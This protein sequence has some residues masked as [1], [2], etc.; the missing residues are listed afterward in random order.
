MAKKAPAKTTGKTTAKAPAKTPAKR[1]AK[2]ESPKAVKSGAPKSAAKKASS[3]SYSIGEGSKAPQI[4][5]AATSN[6]NLSN[7]DFSGRTVVLYFYPKD[8]TPGCTL[9]GQDF[10]RLYK[11]FQE[12]KTEIVGVSQDTVASHEK[13]K[14]KCDFPFELLSDE[15][16][17]LCKAFDVIQMKNMYGREFMGIERSTFVIKDGQIKK[18]WRKVKVD[19][20]AQEVLDFVKGL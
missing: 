7:K 12:A 1:V 17:E 13:F 16:G 3:K 5:G 6:R 14:A 20:H 9:E 19:G 11:K 8:N 10:R 4:S 15:S 18:E 2:S